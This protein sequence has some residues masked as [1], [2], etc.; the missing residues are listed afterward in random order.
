MRLTLGLPEYQSDRSSNGA[1]AAPDVGTTASDMDMGLGRV[2]IPRNEERRL[3]L[4]G[5]LLA[6][7]AGASFHGN[8]NKK[9]GPQSI[10]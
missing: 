3:V 8:T 7:W 1:G 9:V 2:L 6:P 4:Y 5:A 10:P